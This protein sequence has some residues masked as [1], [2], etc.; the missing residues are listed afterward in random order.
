MW[1]DH[2]RS[3]SVRC[4][5]ALTTERRAPPDTEVSFSLDRK[6]EFAVDTNIPRS[7]YPGDSSEG[8]QD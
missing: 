5:D 4:Q 8:C 6:R 7:V 1:E 3:S 2:L